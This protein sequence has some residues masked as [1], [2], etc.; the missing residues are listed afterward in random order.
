MNQSFPQAGGRLR[1]RS[2][3]NCTSTQ[4]GVEHSETHHAIVLA[5]APLHMQQM[6][7]LLIAVCFI[8]DLVVEHDVHE[9]TM[10]LHPVPAILNEA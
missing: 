10:N 1:D 7:D 4:T 2:I 6:P 3:S 9:G 8:A 5:P